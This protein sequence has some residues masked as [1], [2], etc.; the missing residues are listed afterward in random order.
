MGP[1]QPPPA[2][3]L[4]LVHTLSLTLLAFAGVA[5]LA[6]GGLTAWHLRNGFGEYLASRDVLH[7]ERFV[8][9]LES[10]LARDDGLSALRDGRLGLNGLLD[11]LSPRPRPADRRLPGQH[12]PPTSGGSDGFPQRLQ[13]VAPDGT[14]LLGQPDVA[15]P[16]AVPKVER[17]VRVNG[18]VVAVARMR[19]A[20]MVRT[21][22]EARFLRD[23]YT[24]IAAGGLGLLVLGVLTATWLARRWTRPLAAV[25]KATQRLAQGE[26]TVRLPDDADLAGRSDEIGDVV[27]NVNRMAE[28]LQQLE[29][30]RRRWLAD[31]SHELRTPLTVLRGDIE[32]LHDGVRP[33]RPEAIAV[34][35]EEVLRLNKL[36]DDLHLLAISDLQT[37]PC[38]MAVEDALA[39]VRRLHRRY[40]ARAHA[41]GL[42]LRL[43]VPDDLSA[44]DELPVE[45]DAGRI[46]QL[47]DNLL[48]NS[49][50]YTESPGQV[51][52]RLAC[53]DDRVR[54][55]VE[56]SAP[57]VPAA[58]RSQLFEPLYRG[59]AARRSGAAG[60]GLGLAICQTI[61][62]AHG[63]RLVA[64]ASALGGLCLTLDLP[65][66]T[67]PV[68]SSTG[69]AA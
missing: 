40:A 60:S 7:F 24:L 56:D 59:D 21:G 67:S 69:G 63:G 15:R 26:L 17:P 53:V 38:H 1:L 58:Q 48:E 11:E 68:T 55:V 31:I 20:P 49:L 23:Q 9:I 3:R 12:P 22:A 35:H 41:A 6:L 14:V 29:G 61:A 57:G 46:E 28:G 47:L 65:R 43:E 5:V 34:L 44:L 2:M 42:A 30:V 13:V 36:V 4:R 10:R 18:E 37:L 8:G 62:K 45:W 50:R 32:A 19:P 16:N 52:V 51:L 33:L 27:R 25:Q 66:S 64:S 39:L 54:V